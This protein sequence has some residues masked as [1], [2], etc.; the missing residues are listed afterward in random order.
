MPCQ[1]K[2]YEGLKTWLKIPLDAAKAWNA[3]NAF[4]HSAAVSFY[5]LFSLAPVTII[6]VTIVGFFL[7]REQAS[8]Q[9][10]TQITQLIGAASAEV[11]AAAAKASE[12]K[13]ATW[14]ATT[15][16]IVLL[17]VGATTVFGQ[18]QDS[19]NDI[20]G[21]RAKPSRSGWVVIIFQRLISFAM[22]L[23]IGF[24][25]LVSLAVSTALTAFFKLFDQG[26]L[27]SPALLQAANLGVGL[28]VITVLFALLFKVLPDVK[29]RWRDVW[30]GA[31]ITS[32][33]FSL[34]RYLI[35]LYLGHS[36]VASIYGTAGSLVALLIWVYYS[37][38]IL[39]YGVEFTYAYRMAQ[40][41]DVDPKPTAVRVREQIIETKRGKMARR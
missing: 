1:C 34:G 23:T 24:L 35:A 27:A 2:D 22:V 18:L 4:K 13:D 38:A 10:Q 37:C 29:L 41:L 19:L 31:F 5:T 26:L 20:W 21:V 14:F 3:D 33:L 32:L 11:V 28:L 15:V 30:I 12:Q 17:L 6:V 40:G 16:G 39:F 7:G 8:Q 25:L 9:F 36:T